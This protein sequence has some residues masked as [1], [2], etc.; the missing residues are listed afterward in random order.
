MRKSKNAIERFYEKIEPEE[1]RGRLI[2]L[3]SYLLFRCGRGGCDIRDSEFCNETNTSISFVIPR[4]ELLKRKGLIDFKDGRYKI[5]TRQIKKGPFKATGLEWPVFLNDDEVKVEFQTW[6][7]V[8]M[9]IK[10]SAVKAWTALFQTQI[11]FLEKSYS[12]NREL[13]LEH[14]QTAIINGYQGFHFQPE[15]KEWKDRY[16]QYLEAKEEDDGRA[17]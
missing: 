9:S 5:K 7:D 3:Y 11:K 12:P 10:K 17:F 15:G 4:L 6:M 2:H 8:R 14:I 16:R 13:A 1:L